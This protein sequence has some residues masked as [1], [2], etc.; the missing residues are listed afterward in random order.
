MT[1][2][3]KVC[4][5][6][7]SKITRENVIKITLPANTKS[8]IQSKLEFSTVYGKGRKVITSKPK[9]LYFPKLL[10]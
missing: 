1:I 9:S 6:K 10:I 8:R 2:Q 7:S 3:D 5:V 4:E